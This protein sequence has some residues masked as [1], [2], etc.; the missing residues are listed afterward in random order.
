MRASGDVLIRI[1]SSP[2]SPLAAA[3]SE[4]EAAGTS[5]RLEPLFEVPATNAAGATALAARDRTAVWHLARATG[6]S[7]GSAWDAVYQLAERT[8]ANLGA[9]G[10]R[11]THAEPDLIQEWPTD[12][13]DYI[14][15]GI[16]DGD[17][18][19][20]DDKGRKYAFPTPRRF[21]WHLD[22]AFTGLAPAR[23]RA[24]QHKTHE[25]RVAHLDVGYGLHHVI[26]PAGFEPML[27][28]NVTGDGRSER[29]VE[30]QVQSG[31][32]TN[33]GHGTGTVGLLAGGRFSFERSGYKTFNDQIGAAPDA[34][35]VG[36]R[37]ASS[38]VQIRTSAVARAISYVAD[39]CKSEATQVH[40]LSMSMGGVA[41]QAWADAVN[42]A[43]ERGVILVTAAG[44]N[45][46]VGLGGVPTTS[47]VYPA[48]FQRVLSAC[49][50]MGNYKPYYGLGTGTMQGNWGP[51]E[52]DATS[53]AAFTPNTS[54]AR[55][56]DDRVV[57][58]DGAGT[59]SATPQIAGAA[60]LYLQRHGTTLFDP[61]KYPQPW[62]RVEA[63]RA[64]LTRSARKNFADDQLKKFGSG[65]LQAKAALGVAPVPASQ[66]KLSPVANCSFAFFHTLFGVG[67]KADAAALDSQLQ[68]EM[69][70]LVQQWEKGDLSEPESKQ[71]N[72][73]DAILAEAGERTG[74]LTPARQR[75]LARKIL[76]HP[77]AST[78]LKKTLSRL[79]GEQGP[80]KSGEK[81]GEGKPQAL[82]ARQPTRFQPETP[83][84]RALRGYALDP[85][86]AVSLATRTVSETVYEVPWD[87]K[88]GPGPCDAY[89][90]VT[91]VDPAS[92][93]VYEPVD[94]NH[95]N[96][97][98]TQ[99]LAP[100]EGTPQFHQ[101]MVY[102]VVRTTIDHFESAL[103]RKALWRPGPPPEGKN[104]KD[105]SVYVPRLRVYPHA[106]RDAN[107][108]YSPDKI[109]LL[110]GY[111]SSLGAPGRGNGGRPQQVFTCL[112]QDI[113][114]H[115][116]THALLDGMHRKYLKN[117][118]KD[119]LA[120]HEA[121]ADIVAL[122][123]RLALPELLRHQI[124]LTQGQIRDRR[125]LLGELATQFGQAM[126]ERGGLREAIGK[127]DPATGVWTPMEP[128]GDEYDAY[129]EP[130]SRGS[131]LVAAVFDAFL[132][133]YERRTEDLVR[134][135]S[136]G[137]GILKLGAIH[138]DL[139][140]RL[141]RE[142]TKAASHV[143][144]MCIRA[145][146]YCPPTDITF[147]EYLRAIVTADFDLVPDDD[148][149]Y[150]VAMIEAFRRRGIP[151]EE[152]RTVSVESLLWRRERDEPQRLSS[153]F[154][155]RL[156]EFYEQADAHAFTTDREVIFH[157]QRAV[158]G[159]IHDSIDKHFR[160]TKV[161][162]DDA[163]ILGLDPGYGFEVHTA[164][165]ATRVGPDGQLLTQMIIVL[166]QEDRKRPLGYG[167]FF[168]G[169][170][171]IIADLSSQTVR[172]IVRKSISSGDRFKRQK[173]FSLALSRQGDRMAYFRADGKN[174]EP[175]AALHAEGGF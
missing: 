69:A 64:A 77:R 45:Y 167:S 97:L 48:R 40:V 91:D 24:R 171:T 139:V 33:P 31:T 80:G 166:L 76:T 75:D 15:L 20:E 94:L 44:N 112:S 34:R 147:G 61:K 157:R 43:Y 118:N 82:P 110:F 161:G 115:E 136:E 165:L 51:G 173:D 122:L 42:L 23:A 71:G 163:C 135:A 150:R 174:D 16:A 131:I 125:S 68:L 101:Q 41:S 98:A 62:M 52:K 65:V 141:A 149:G 170:C 35:I 26:F 107:A 133:I 164:R 8:S 86:F 175:F 72:P 60:A 130:H 172:Y 39:L 145:L 121:F 134:I 105:D 102:A 63:V 58:M 25:V 99:G 55:R 158:R 1:E 53:L 2:D 138:P 66:L 100:S 14:G 160:K 27:S 6:T 154:C 11:V 156:W 146:D 10:A 18:H 88:L 37:V 73:F 120:F 96:L 123:Q 36:V 19:D 92:R 29:D 93:T 124:A 87:E 4:L 57:D 22:D 140:A 119:V 78:Y 114:A 109:A 104:A 103:G 116:T 7:I 117:T 49:G 56:S 137:T 83:R 162:A 59:S 127:A 155:R 46:S 111:F 95:V 84:F 81:G 21:A 50:V 168:E 108:Y 9:T 70:Q 113:V 67:L 128:T 142:A 12:S 5:F 90:Q 143:L 89:V 132:S 13:P 30:D 153:E 54:W 38:V 152:V 85:S 28:R 106:F 129:D 151:V 159:K 169:G 3:P 79:L 144:R 148:L 32:L 47:T 74:G 126:G 17:F